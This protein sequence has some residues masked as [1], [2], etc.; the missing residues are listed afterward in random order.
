MSYHYIFFKLKNSSH[1]SV[2]RYNAGQDHWEQQKTVKEVKAYKN[3]NPTGFLYKTDGSER[4]YMVLKEDRLIDMA[5]DIVLVDVSSGKYVETS[6]TSKSTIVPFNRPN[7]S[8]DVYFFYQDS[9][10]TLNVATLMDDNNELGLNLTGLSGLDTYLKKYKISGYPSMVHLYNHLD[11]DAQVFYTNSDN[12]LAS[13][14]VDFTRQKVASQRTYSGI[15][16]IGS[17]SLIYNGKYTVFYRGQY[18]ELRYATF[19]AHGVNAGNFL[20]DGRLVN[21]RTKVLSSPS[22]IYDNGEATVYFI[23]DNEK[24][25]MYKIDMTGNSPSIKSYRGNFVDGSVA[26]GDGDAPFAIAS[27]TR[28]L[29]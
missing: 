21:N 14:N 2:V 10:G 7:H 5:T 18:D 25:W 29:F 13:F 9:R 6:Y 4:L 23:G 1:G 26:N 19:V 15:T 28:V 20:T 17:P 22:V 8:R 12:K 16:V 27:D 11:N 3:A 24:M